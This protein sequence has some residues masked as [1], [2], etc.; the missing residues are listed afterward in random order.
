MR[1]DTIF[2]A[3]AVRHPEKEA[4]VCGS[5][6][7]SYGE[8]DRRIRSVATGLLKLG[9]KP[10]DRLV[11]YLPNGIELVEL[12]YAAFSVGV[13]AVPV[14]TRLTPLE[15]Q[16]ICR[17]SKPFA[18]ALEAASAQYAEVV[19]N[20]SGP[21]FIITGMNVSG[22]VPMA[23]L[24]VND[25]APLHFLPFADDALVLYTSG[26]TGAPKGAV[27]TH[28]NL[29]VQNYFVHAV[30]WGITRDDNYLVTTP[31]AHRAGLARLANALSLG[32]T[33]VIL[34]SFDPVA[35]VLAIEN[36]K[37]T[38][39]GMVPTICRMLLPAIQDDP[40][41]CESLRCIVVTGEA[42][43]AELKRK[44]LSLLPHVRLVSFFAMTEAGAVTSLSHEE[45]LVRPESIGRP[46][47]GVEIRIVDDRGI[48]T[49]PGQPGELLVRSGEPGR[50]TVM[51]CY[52][53]RPEES[54]TAL[55][56]G[57]LHTGDIAKCD[58]LGYL[59]IIDRKKDM[60]ITGGLNVY[61]KEV[62][63]ALLANPGIADAAVVGIPDDVYGES[64]VAFV[65]R[66][67]DSPLTVEDVIATAQERVAGY[68]KP[69]HVF[70][71]D[72]LPR[73]GTGK[74][75]KHELRLRAEL[76]LRAQ[77]QAAKA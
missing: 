4:L 40:S 74:V 23:E 60:I 73:N 20:V 24:R 8:L 52:Y 37:V 56:D 9:A 58:E 49:H 71:V 17:D 39:A 13:I 33:L 66:P 3:Q 35:A 57:W 61:T 21:A 15:L 18:V 26:T 25:A 53:E 47:P 42:F 65:E 76:L 6:R 32:G 38:V 50:F 46:T 10:G 62:E 43:P 29:V 36:E 77:P 12:L 72:H 2:R 68:K 55:R 11:I 16:Y 41:R 69:R 14:S 5:D 19:K 1:L 75:L 7:V 44:F 63:Q 54:A 28:S 70:L 48:D 59:Y 30:E 27:I 31:L 34:K 22:T 45:Q 51:R 67:A 64:V